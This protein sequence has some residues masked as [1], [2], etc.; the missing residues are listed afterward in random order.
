MGVV[1]VE[2]YAHYKEGIEVQAE[3]QK[4]KSDNQETRVFPQIAASPN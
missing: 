4:R 2:L 1:G 3:A